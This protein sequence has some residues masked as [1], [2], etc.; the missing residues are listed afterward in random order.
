MQIEFKEGTMSIDPRL[1]AIR[2]A[3]RA[4]AQREPAEP[5][6]AGGIALSLAPVQK[7]AGEPRSF[8]P[9]NTSGSFDRK[10]NWAR[11]GKR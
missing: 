5:A 1:T 10:Q 2:R 4:G 9:Y 3:S 8:D 11:V 6:A 7:S